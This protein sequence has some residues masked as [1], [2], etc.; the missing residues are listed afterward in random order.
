MF[1]ST[2][3]FNIILHKYIYTYIYI[4]CAAVR[5]YRLQTNKIGC[6]D[7][8]NNNNNNNN[9][10]ELTA[11]VCGVLL[12]TKKKY[13]TNRE[14]SDTNK[15]RDGTL[16]PCLLL[17]LPPPL[18]RQDLNAVCDVN[19][20]DEAAVMF[21]DPVTGLIVI[22]EDNSTGERV[23]PLLRVMHVED[24]HPR[25]LSLSLSLCP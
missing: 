4:C 17:Q 14:H 22:V 21:V 23:L 13:Q 10:N 18:S 25:S 20:R 6:F 8:N 9:K 12:L 15:K 19:C 11:T 7:N 1:I 5:R 3:L 24:L 16:M 2:L